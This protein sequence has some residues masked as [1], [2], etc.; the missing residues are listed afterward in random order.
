MTER[1]THDLVQGSPEW[2][3]FRLKHFGASEAAAMLGLSK[4][5]KRNEL[6]HMKHTGMPKEFS[7]WVQEHILDRGHEVE[8]LARPL[9]EMTLGE[10]LYPMVFSNGRMSASCDGL[11]MDERRAWEH[12]QW[13]EE[14]ANSVRVGILPEE[15][16]PQCQQVLMVSEADELIF[17]VSDG[18]DDRRVSM[19]VRPDPEW[20]E[21]I[22]AG[23]RQFERDLAE[24]API[25]ISE[26]A[27]A[28]PQESLPVPF[29]QVTGSIAIKSNLDLFGAALRS[30]IDQIPEKPETDQ[31][32]ADTDAACKRLKDAEDCLM[33]AEDTALASVSDIEQLRRTV[34]TLRE[35]TRQ[36]RLAK[37]KLVEARKKQIKEDAITER[38]AKWTEHIAAINAELKAVQI[39]VPAPDFVGAIKGL[40]TIASLYDKLDTALANG[41]I[42][43]DAAAKDL[44]A[45]LNWYEP[46]REAHGFLFRD[47]QTLIQK[48]AEDFELAVKT[49]IDEHKRAE[50][51]KAKAKPV[52]VIP[53]PTITS[54][55]ITTRQQTLTPWTESVR[56]APAGAPTLRLG[57]INER[58]APITLT[59][60]GLAT[61][62]FTHAATDKA[63]KL[64]HEADF[65]A[66]CAALTRHIEAALRKQAA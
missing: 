65:E 40:K 15:H 34:A 38:R 39:M 45:K 2:M 27:I 25:E 54:T 58:L 56:S 30:F 13:A 53:A 55:P 31:D 46:H 26:K 3:E 1:I 59:A 32:F 21:K 48:P 16:L 12:K 57:Q 43:A 20:F 60:D 17:T 61:F 9:I 18:T 22:R 24:Y 50:E 37:E 19:I 62:G 41:K 7:D 47:L 14:L 66:I 4:N 42:V 36:T 49:R 11:T 63:A 35:L 64:Y 33:S 10:D 44:R 52:E 28:A 51:E 8:A 6:L 5:V 23:W 29:A